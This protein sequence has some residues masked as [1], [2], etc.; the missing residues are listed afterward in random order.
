MIEGEQAYYEFNF[1]PSGQWRVYAFRAYR[2][3]APLEVSIHSP[4]IVTSTTTE[5]LELIARL[6]LADLSPFHSS[7]PLCL[8]LAAVVETQDGSLSFWALRHS[9]GRPDFHQ[10]ETFALRVTAPRREA[11]A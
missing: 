9:S 8:G 6:R 7:S 3:P 2:F 4:S 1:A 11:K 5:R 10:A